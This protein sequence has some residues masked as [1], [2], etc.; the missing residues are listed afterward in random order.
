[1][2]TILLRLVAGLITTA[3]PVGLVRA[4]KILSHP[5][6]KLGGGAFLL[7]LVLRLLL[8]RLLYPFLRQVGLTTRSSGWHYWIFAALYGEYQSNSCLFVELS[9]HDLSFFRIIQL[10]GFLAQPIYAI[11]RTLLRC[12]RS[13]MSLS[14]FQVLDLGR[15]SHFQGSRQPRP[16]SRGDWRLVQGHLS[17]LGQRELFMVRRPHGYLYAVGPY[18]GG[19]SRSLVADSTASVGVVSRLAS[20]QTTSGAIPGMGDSLSNAFGKFEHYSDP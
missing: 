5:A 3:L 8:N 2:W 17:G 19:S 13:G 20:C 4:N 16:R 15:R 12:H 7:C 18:G 11:Y 9:V 6:S 14:T 10:A 1:M